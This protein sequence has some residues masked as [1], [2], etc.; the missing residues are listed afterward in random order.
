ML[1]KKYAK[2]INQNILLRFIKF[3]EFVNIYNFIIG[4]GLV[5]SN[6]E[7]KNYIKNN[8]DQAYQELFGQV[9]RQRII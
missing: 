2:Y 1:N 9:K 7:I 6:E 3:S 4:S 8:N 5:V